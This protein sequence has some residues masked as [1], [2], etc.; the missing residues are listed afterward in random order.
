L[1]GGFCQYNY[2]KNTTKYVD[3]YG[4]E[5][6][7][8]EE[9]DELAKQ[10]HSTLPNES[11]FDI[12]NM[13]TTAVGVDSNG[14]LHVSSSAKQVPEPIQEWAA[15]NNVSVYESGKVNMHGEEALRN[16]GRGIE[17]IGSSRPICIHCETG[18]TRN[19]I[20]F[21][22]SNVSGKVSKN[23]KPGGKYDGTTGHWH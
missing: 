10:A 5:G 3:P 18:M 15:K 9:L 22:K 14:N 17:K 4:L 7:T 19:K 12:G 8:V 20:E 6:F 13:S 11:R 16:S 2:V 1:E 21:N 23:R